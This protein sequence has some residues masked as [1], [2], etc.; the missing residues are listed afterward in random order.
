MH[1]YTEDEVRQLTAGAGG[2]LFGDGALVVLKALLQAGMS[3]FGGYPGSPTANLIDAAADAYEDVLKPLGVYVES[4]ANE[5]SAAALLTASVYA[6]V[7]GAVTWKVLGN[8]VGSDVLDHIAALGVNGGAMIVVGEDYGVS[9]TS[10]AIRTLPWAMKSGI[11]VVDP[12]GD[13]QILSRMVGD[14]M[15][16]SE[17]ARLPVALLMRPQMS[18]SRG[19]IRTEDNAVGR[20]S[21]RNR[22]ASIA[23]DPSKTP[24][25]PNSQ[26]Q[27]ASKWLERVPAAADFVLSRGMNERFGKPSAT[28]GVI[29]HGLTF[30]T[31]MR[32]LQLCDLAGLDGTLDPQ[33]EI[34]Q[35]NVIHPIPEAEIV[36]F[37]RGKTDVLLV[38]E[39]QPELIEQR[40]TE[41]LYKNKSEVRFD[42]HARVPRVGELTPDRLLP[43]VTGFLSEVM[44]SRADHLHAAAESARAARRRAQETLPEAVPARVPTF[45][46]GCPERPV[47]SMMKIKEEQ[48]GQVDFHAGDVGCYGMAGLAPFWMADSNIGMGAGLAA[49]TGIGALSDQ[50]VTSVVGDGTLWHSALNTN[51]VNAMNNN[52]DATYIVLDNGWTAMTGHHENPST[53]R[54]Y[55]GEEL[56]QKPDIVRTLTGMGLGVER[57]NPYDFKEFGGKLRELNERLAPQ[58]RVLVSEGECQ[59]ERQRRVRPQVKERIASGKRQPVERLGV[60]AEVCVGDHA[61]IR[62]NGCPSL[63]LAKSSNTL[64]TSSVAHI[65]DTCVGCGVC[66]EIAHTARLCP[67]F[68][69]ATVVKNP[70]WYERPLRWASRRLVPAGRTAA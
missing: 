56:K 52:Q 35:L 14:A 41:I 33:I 3:Y 44:P 37:V 31:V 68:Y 36:S 70:R 60:D 46:T 10:V 25:P 58:L 47:F 49:A 54:T 6:P 18:H 30:N 57:A 64:R 63:T 39:G 16:M 61:C 45:C 2:T 15:D 27:E 13:L 21:T 12:R 51:V 59:L 22:I 40:I 9:S 53:G 38:E 69:K 65:D 5:M 23:K 19:V 66:G 28:T 20:F 11:L 48:T 32:I 4:S 55:T 34:L 8:S 67:S 26:Q 24:L 29:T 17:A 43:A 50:K 62:Y 7:R 42:G 1:G